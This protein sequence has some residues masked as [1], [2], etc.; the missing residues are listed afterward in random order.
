MEALLKS[1]KALD[2]LASISLA[3]FVIILILL[4]GNGI[5]VFK[6]R[7]N[8]KNLLEDYRT[9]A[10]EKEEM[11]NK[12]IS[13]DK[14]ITQLKM[15]H[16]E[17]MEAFYQKQ[18]S[19]RQQ[20]IS[21]Q[22]DIDKRFDNITDKI[23]ELIILIN[24]QYKETNS[25]KRNE[26]REKLLSHYRFFTSL[27][28]NPKQEWTEMEAEV[29]WTLFEDYKKLGGNGFMHNT[30]KPAMEALKVITIN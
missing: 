30:V 16:E 18:M 8:I 20:S 13:H 28:H 11:K 7:G 26:L 17:D 29:F 19:Y 23:N 24:E 25:I 2:I 4:I 9:K 22:E 3:Q 10:N 12:I 6:F 5:I 1:D 14:A 15:H 27:E 21:K